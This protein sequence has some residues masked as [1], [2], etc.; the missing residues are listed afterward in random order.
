MLVSPFPPTLANCCSYCSSPSRFVHRAGRPR[1]A[2][3]CD[4]MRA[5][6]CSDFLSDRL[7]LLAAAPASG[8]LWLLHRCGEAEQSTELRVPSSVLSLLATDHRCSATTE[9]PRSAA[10]GEKRPEG[11]RNERSQPAEERAE[12]RASRAARRWRRIKL[13]RSSL[14]LSDSICRVIQIRLCSEPQLL[15]CSHREPPTHS[16]A[17]ATAAMS[18]TSAKLLFEG[19][20]AYAADTRDDGI[21]PYLLQRRKFY[22]E[23][24]WSKLLQQ[25]ANTTTLY[26]GNLSF[27]T[28][29]EQLLELFSRVGH[30]RRLIMGLNKASKTPCGFCFVEMSSHAEAQSAQRFLSGTSVDERVIRADLDPGFEEGRQYGR[31]RQ[32]G[33]QR[34][35]DFRQEF[36]AG[37]GGWAPP[38]QKDIFPLFADHPVGTTTVQVR[39]GVVLNANAE[40]LG[41]RIGRAAEDASAKAF[42]SG[43]AAAM[44]PV[45]GRGQK[46]SRSRERQRVS[47]SP[48]RHRS[49][50]RSRERDRL[51]EERNE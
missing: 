45:A 11:T 20:A 10:E 12:R 23:D 39:G 3:V 36:D 48:G 29:E 2:A 30:V 51:R 13:V 15:A 1:I 4:P 38:P 14:T 31:S 9:G 35:D 19:M 47:D 22:S 18:V 43:G 21:S 44:A 26:V 28:T 27:F 40:P 41:I 42:A 34:R 8:W 16:T 5:P 46:R 32:S 37:R 17:S 24:A 50:S 7:L 6:A 25:L 33:G 49:R